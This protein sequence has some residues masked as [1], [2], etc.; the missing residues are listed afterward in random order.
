MT[1]TYAVADVGTLYAIQ[2]QS[3][4]SAEDHSWGVRVADNALVLVLAS[5]VQGREDRVF[6]L[7]RSFT[8]HDLLGWTSIDNLVP[9]EGVRY[10]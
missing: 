5:G 6:C 8:G 1:T 9:I 7:T 4:V 2:K 3:T 10:Y